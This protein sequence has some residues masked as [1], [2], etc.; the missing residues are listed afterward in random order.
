MAKISWDKVK[1]LREELNSAQIVESDTTITLTTKQM[2][3][4]YV[5]MTAAGGVSLPG[6]T[7]ANGWNIIVYTTSGATIY[8]DPDANDKFVLDGTALS[9]GERIKSRGSLENKVKLLNDSADGWTVWSG[10][11]PLWIAD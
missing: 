8:V 4:Q 10:A 6:V 5:N 9:D 3:N 7:G 2:F 1:R 11:T